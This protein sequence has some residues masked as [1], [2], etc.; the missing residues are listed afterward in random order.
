MKRNYILSLFTIAIL[1]P[2]TALKAQFHIGDSLAL[3]NIRTTNFI[4][5]TTGIT[6]TDPNPANWL[7]VEWN[8]ATPKRVVKLSLDADGTISGKDFYGGVGMGNIPQEDGFVDIGGVDAS[9]T[10][11]VDFSGLA[12]LRMLDLKNQGAITAI[13]ITGLNNLERFIINNT[14]A[15]ITSFDFSNMTNLQVVGMSYGTD[16]ITSINASNCPRLKSL[17]CKSDALVSVNI[18]GSDSLEALL[19]NAGVLFDSIDVSSKTL[20]KHLKMKNS[21]SLRIVTGIQNCDSLININFRRSDNFTGSFD[22]ADYNAANFLRFEIDRTKVEDVLN[23]SLLG[24]SV[25]RIRIERAR[26]TLSN[27][28]QIANEVANG[29][30]NFDNQTRHGGDTVYVGGMTDFPGEDTIDISGTLVASTFTLFDGTGTQVGGTNQTGNFMFPNL[31]DTGAYYVDMSNPG[32]APANNTVN[33]R[34]DTF[35][36]A[37][38]PQ[39]DTVTSV[40]LTTITVAQTNATYQWLDCDNGNTVIAGATSQSY[41]ATANGNYA[42]EITLGGV[43]KDTSACVNIATV[44]LDELSSNTTVRAYPNPMNEQVTIELQKVVANTQVTIVN[45]EGKVVYNNV[46]N[47]G[48]ISVDGSTWNNGIYIVKITNEEYTKTLKLIK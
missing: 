2:F 34:T 27:A 15:A 47:T 4:G 37:E 17:K 28:T 6:W 32:A 9:L 22:F 14:N 7:G 31:T 40:S 26:L 25:N 11:A 20:L 3:Q 13:N 23:W 44:G 16:A 38:C 19:L 41:T 18:T 45:V 24:A 35:W 29:I 36:V 21:D 33:L 39:L 5:G 30:S 10:G 43:C 12:D 48:K 46:V 1:M 42:V 8:T